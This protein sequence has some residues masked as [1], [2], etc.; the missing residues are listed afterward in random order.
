[1]D[2][3]LSAFLK[4]NQKVKKNAHVAVSDMFV[5]KDGN[6]I[7]W[8]IRPV[9]TKVFERLRKDCTKTVQSKKNPG[10]TEQIFNGDLY[11]HKLLVESVVFPDLYNAD[12][13]DSYGVHTPEA[14]LNSLLPDAGD[15]YRLMKF[16][17]DFN[18]FNNPDPLAS[19][20]KKAKN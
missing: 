6:P 13:Q 10:Q 15:F 11:N 4:E 14:L 8:E 2:S 17:E 1:M 9:S 20:I 3:K 7:K 19:D 12:L 18:G 16:V 5:D